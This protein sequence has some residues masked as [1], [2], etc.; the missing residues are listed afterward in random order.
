ML[1]LSHYEFFINTNVQAARSHLWIIN[2]CGG[3]EPEARIQNLE[4]E[5]L[6]LKSEFVI[7]NP[8]DGNSQ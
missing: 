4:C 6:N 3:D 5:I 8:G 2:S 1:N 7:C